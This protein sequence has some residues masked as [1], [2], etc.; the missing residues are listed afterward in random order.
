MGEQREP[1]QDFVEPFGT[2]LRRLRKRRGLRQI[3]L[4]VEV[5]V[6]HSL[7]SRWETG[8]VLPAAKDLQ[9]ICD[10]LELTGTDADEL[11]YAWQRERN[12]ST[13]DELTVMNGRPVDEWIESL[14]VSVDCVRALR[15]A[16]QPRMALMLSHRDA[17]TAFDR[18]RAHPWTRA[19]P[20]A[21]SGLSELLLEECKASL[22][23]LP[24]AAVRAGEL[25][26]TLHVHDLVSRSAGDPTARLFHT[27]AR[28]G[29]SYVAGNIG[30]AHELSLSLLD[31]HENIPPEWIPEVVRACAINAGK[32]SDAAAIT[33]AEHALRVLLDSRA[34]LSAGTH[35]FVLEGLARGW[36]R[37]D[38]R[39]ATEVIGRAWELRT[40]S[41]DS[42]SNSSVRHVQLVRSQA[43][44]E[45]ALRSTADRADTLTRIESALAI[46]RRE[47]YD[48]Y[49]LELEALA[50]R[51]G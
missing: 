2:A 7:V 22:D 38:P 12:A 36:S 26:R 40:D 19:H 51:L 45:I 30:T 18:L 17:E 10:A 27:L 14:R 35:A 5:P 28:E 16:G 41:D 49:V 50:A 48:K 46:S 24:G 39:K 4:A 9:G 3:E 20:Q 32:L 47:G 31:D 25:D 29:A 13:F 21:L 15:K 11:H 42:E 44:V 23:Y 33:R 34:D 1:Q 37:V 8:H 6:D 43:E